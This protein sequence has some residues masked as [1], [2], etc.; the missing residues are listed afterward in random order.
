MHFEIGFQR[1]L[2]VDADPGLL[3]IVALLHS[4]LF[5]SFGGLDPEV[6]KVLGTPRSLEKGSLPFACG[7]EKAL[8][9]LTFPSLRE[10]I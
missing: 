8:Q 3:D 10:G 2:W 1:L 7:I 5:V 4:S 9:P 6:E